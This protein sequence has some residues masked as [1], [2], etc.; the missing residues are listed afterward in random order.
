M[1]GR[2]KLAKKLY[3][4]TEVA[5]ILGVDTWRIKNFTEGGAYGLPPS[6]QAGRGRGSRRLYD[7]RDI[8]RILIA[9][10][11]VWCGFTPESIGRAIEEIPRSKLVGRDYADSESEVLTHSGEE[12][13]VVAQEFVWKQSRR[14]ILIV[15][16]F[17]QLIL[18]LE[19]DIRRKED[20]E[21]LQREFPDVWREE[22]RE[23]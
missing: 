16:P 10:H 17:Q 4:T 14:N 1:A 13:M 6:M 18:D 22:H 3:T 19:N 21:F 12:W 23:D 5:Q 20:D 15:I 11:L 8:R 2:R 9:Q 7:W